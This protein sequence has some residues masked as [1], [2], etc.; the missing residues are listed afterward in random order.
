MTCF[1]AITAMPTLAFIEPVTV[2]VVEPDPR[3]MALLTKPTPLTLEEWA[4]LE[5]VEQSA[6]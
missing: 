6:E 4:Y 5:R 1:I 2:R 3:L